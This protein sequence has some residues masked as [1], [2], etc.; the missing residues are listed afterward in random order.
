MRFVI[1]LACRNH[2]M[3][4]EEAFLA[5]T[6]G[7]AKAIGRDADIGSLERGKKADIQ[8]WDIPEFEHLIYRLD[9][10][11]VVSVIKNGRILFRN[12]RKKS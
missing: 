7:A 11:P 10:N 8:I 12:D 6:M 2:E 4:L 9:H 5:A 3:S 1:L